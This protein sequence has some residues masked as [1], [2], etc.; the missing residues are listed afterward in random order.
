MPTVTGLITV[1]DLIDGPRRAN[2]FIYIARTAAGAAPTGGSFDWPT[3]TLTPPTG[4][5][6]N[7][8]SST[9]VGQQTFTS[10][11]RASENDTRTATTITYDTPELAQVVLNDVKSPNYDGSTDLSSTSTVAN[12]GTEGYFLD[13]SS[14]ILAATDIILRDIDA[15]GPNTRLGLGAGNP[16]AT[17]PGAQNATFGKSAG[18]RL[19][20]GGTDGRAS[21]SVMVGD[22]AGMSVTTGT[23]NTY[24]GEG[25]G[26]VMSSGGDMRDITGSQNIGIGRSALGS[27]NRSAA[28]A[29]SG[30]SNVAI[31]NRSG[32]ELTTGGSNV[33]VG[34]GAGTLLTTGS[35]N[36]L[37]GNTSGALLTTGNENFL[38]GH[39]AG[40]LLS[41]GSDNTLLGP[42]A[43]LN[44][45]T[46]D[47][48]T[49]VGSGAGLNLSGVSNSVMVGHNAGRSSTSGSNTFI[50]DN[51][52]Y[53]ADNSGAFELPLTSTGGSNVGIG[54]LALGN[55]NRPEATGGLSGSNNIGV[56]DD[57][58]ISLTSGYSNTLIGEKAGQKITT[59]FSNVFIGEE[60]GASVVGGHN[61]VL[62]GEDAD[63]GANVGGG[64]AIGTSAKALGNF[65]IS[66]GGS[67]ASA[68]EIRIGQSSHTGTVSVGPY[69]LADF[70]EH[71][72][73]APPT[74]SDDLNL[75]V[76]ST[77]ETSINV[78]DSLATLTSLGVVP[79]ATIQVGSDPT[80][81]AAV[82]FVQDDTVN[83]RRRIIADAF[84]SWTVEPIN[85]PLFL[86][87]GVVGNYVLNLASDLTTYSWVL[88]TDTGGG[89]SGNPYDFGTTTTPSTAFCISFGSI[90]APAGAFDAGAI[91]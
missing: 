23:D 32:S 68:G 37:L 38:A 89:G 82:G 44:L 65:A 61:N 60:V 40:A 15:A 71:L 14:G 5:S 52:G 84:E 21:N 25:A 19:D 45:A 29:I 63:A 80:N 8:P 3:G 47:G 78:S 24:I 9:T 30:N 7:A 75:S 79:G 72:P 55:L 18:G 28:T 20:T 46:G 4:W 88:A 62:I 22:N 36:I 39:Q 11:W 59:G 54:R 85:T 67:E 87:V 64:I 13:A 1:S 12:I 50:G 17:N 31:G 35:R 49:L 51:A 53:F 48:N 6:L 34:N 2:G 10:Y 81:R 90:L 26:S 16:M 57:T 43:G 41:T 33:L 91:E 73:D 42:F 77:T 76:I 66:I 56:G 83:S 86:E 69:N 70:G 27:S 74:L 58:G